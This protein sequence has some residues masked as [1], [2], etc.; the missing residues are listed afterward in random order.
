MLVKAMDDYSDRDY[1]LEPDTDMF[2]SVFHRESFK[3]TDRSNRKM[4][5]EPVLSTIYENNQNIETSK[6]IFVD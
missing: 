4:S 1:R 5:M 3:S 2:S 6:V